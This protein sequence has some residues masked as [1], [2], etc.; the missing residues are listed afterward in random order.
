MLIQG[1]ELRITVSLGFSLFPV[2]SQK[3]EVLLRNADTALY[4]AKETKNSH[5]IYDES[6]DIF[7]RSMLGGPNVE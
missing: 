7:G 2:H 6:M 1:Q 3:K 4:R 5:R